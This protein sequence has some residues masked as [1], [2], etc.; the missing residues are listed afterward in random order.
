MSETTKEM[1]RFCNGFLH[2]SNIVPDRQS[3]RQ[4]EYLF[5][6]VLMFGTKVEAGKFVNIIYFL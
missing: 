5:Q 6:N 2:E 4:F 3:Q 1:N